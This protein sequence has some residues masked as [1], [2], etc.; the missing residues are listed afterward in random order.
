M[1]SRIDLPVVDPKSTSP[2]NELSRFANI[3]KDEEI[4]VTELEHEDDAAEITK[5][6]WWFARSVRTPSADTLTA[7]GT[8]EVNVN[9]SD[10][11]IQDAAL[12]AS[13]YVLSE[14]STRNCER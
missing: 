11:V 8:L 3:S 9:N 5:L 13:K 4:D 1:E 2:L 12:N 14:K 10:A 6:V 7:L